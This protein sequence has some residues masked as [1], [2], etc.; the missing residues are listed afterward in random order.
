MTDL[1]EK[2]RKA[3][4]EAGLSREALAQKLGIALAQ[5]LDWEEDREVPDLEH[6]ARLCDSLGIT[7]DDLLKGSFN[8]YNHATSTPPSTKLYQNKYFIFFGVSLA[9][10]LFCLVDVFYVVVFERVANRMFEN[11]GFGEVFPNSAFSDISYLL[12]IPSLCIM[13]LG[14][15]ASLYFWNKYQNSK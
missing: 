12:A 3:R 9:V 6:L 13:V 1:G 5:L 2:L 10:S 11:V 7:I 14:F 4:E 8:T 15:G